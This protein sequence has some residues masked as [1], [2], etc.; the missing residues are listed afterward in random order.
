[1]F[2]LN[3]RLCDPKD[4]GAIWSLRNFYK[5]DAYMCAFLSFVFLNELICL[6]K[7]NLG[8]I[9]IAFVEEGERGAPL[10]PGLPGSRLFCFSF[11]KSSNLLK[12]KTTKKNYR[13]VANKNNLDYAR[14]KD[15]M[16]IPCILASA[17]KRKLQIYTRTVE[18]CM[19]HRITKKCHICLFCCA[20]NTRYFTIETII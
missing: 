4:R 9:T 11:L 7:K 8:L 17:K 5:N 20:R 3:I 19:G 16:N 12:T 15:H 10:A 2:R 13:N 14:A 18:F 1:M 6:W